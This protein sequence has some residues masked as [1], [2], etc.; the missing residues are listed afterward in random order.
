LLIFTIE[1]LSF[2]TGRAK[3]AFLIQ[4]EVNESDVVSAITKPLTSLFAGK[5]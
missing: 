2:S 5:E 1:H 3:R 4:T